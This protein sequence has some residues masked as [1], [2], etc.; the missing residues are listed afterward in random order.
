MSEERKPIAAPGK[1]LTFALAQEEYGVSVLKVREIIKMMEI[2]AVPQ[3][4][5]HIRGVIN[6][7]GKVIPIVDLRLKFGVAIAESTNRTCI[8]V[9]DV[10]LGA[11]RILL[12]MI[13]DSVA[14]VLNVAVDE[15]EAA[16]DFGERLDTAYMQGV[17]KIKGSVK[18]LLDLDR[19][20]ASDVGATQAA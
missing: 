16:P 5:R 2:T 19:V 15:I 20:L 9:V 4:P 10:V 17:A 1:Y 18:I 3:V 13:V 7:R 14:E 12:G 6:L 11:R 8:V